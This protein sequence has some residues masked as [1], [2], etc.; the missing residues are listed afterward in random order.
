VHATNILI[1]AKLATKDE[2]VDAY[3]VTAVN[4]QMVLSH[5]PKKFGH[6]FVLVAKQNV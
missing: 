5:H 2:P 6:V 3:D 4:V 1:H